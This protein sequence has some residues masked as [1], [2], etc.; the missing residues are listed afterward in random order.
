MFLHAVSKRASKNLSPCQL[1]NNTKRDSKRLPCAAPQEIRDNE[2]NSKKTMQVKVKAILRKTTLCALALMLFGTSQTAM[3]QRVALKTNALYWA[4]ATPNLGLEF[5]LN[6]HLTLGVEGAVNKLKVNS[7]DTR[8][9]MAAAEMRYWFS[10]RPQARHFVGLLGTA[11]NYNVLL[12]DTRHN[13]DA[14]GFGLT[15]GYS[16]V[17]SRHWSLEATV[18]AGAMRRREKRYDDATEPAPEAPNYDKWNF[19]PLKAGISFVYLIK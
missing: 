13:G 12:K 15:Y 17:L 10:A 16:F 19:A 8:A 11:G 2:H 1:Y 3:A 18:G 4:T 14:M 7:I 9:E 6:R 5:R